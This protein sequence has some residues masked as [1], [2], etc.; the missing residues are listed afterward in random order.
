MDRQ[1]IKHFDQPPRASRITQFQSAEF[2]LCPAH[3]ATPQGQ[4]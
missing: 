4:E 3:L 1:I 2:L